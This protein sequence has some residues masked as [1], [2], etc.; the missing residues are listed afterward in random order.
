MEIAVAD[1]A[2]DRGDEI[3]AVDVA[4][5]ASMHSARREI[6]TQTSVISAR[7]PGRSAIAE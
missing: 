3:G 2:D 7:E 6:G 4:R 1:M 5:V